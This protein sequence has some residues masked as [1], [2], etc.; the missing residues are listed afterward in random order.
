MNQITDRQIL[1]DGQVVF[2]EGQ[3]A[4]VVYLIAQGEIDLIKLSNDNKMEKI[5]TCSAGDF[6]GIKSL[7]GDKNYTVT[8]KVN[9][10]ATIIPVAR[11]KND[12][13]LK[14][15]DKLTLNIVASAL[16]KAENIA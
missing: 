13:E 7:I 15:L 5:A 3:P 8:A 4:S 14:K 11:E 10:A 12:E 6:I 9:G 16:K 2:R 1:N